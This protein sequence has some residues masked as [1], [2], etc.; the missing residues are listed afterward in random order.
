MR[1]NES[2]NCVT[3]L[4][5]PGSGVPLE[6]EREPNGRLVRLAALDRTYVHAP[7]PHR[8]EYDDGFVSTE[9]IELPAG[10]H[11]RVRAG[12]NSW[13][14]SYRSNRK[15]CSSR[16]TARTLPMTSSAA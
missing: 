11:R 9:Q 6:L 3:T 13:T 8:M 5:V 10:L 7:N 12:H 16:S 4:R 15:V 2:G 14:E 1:V